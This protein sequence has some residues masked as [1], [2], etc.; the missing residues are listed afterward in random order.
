MS[1]DELRAFL[2]GRPA[3]PGILA[4]VRADGRPHVAPVWFDVDEDGA[5]VFNTGADTV[6]GRN[7]RREGRAAICVD[8]DAAA[9]Q[10]RDRRGP[11]RGQRGPREVRASAARIGGRYMGDDRAEEIGARNGVPG[12]LLVRLLPDKVTSAADLAE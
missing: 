10:L 5:L 1:P 11:G 9:L 4:T 3:R 7:L 8:D 2:A 12:E 6:K